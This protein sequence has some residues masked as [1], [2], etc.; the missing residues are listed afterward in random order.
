MTTGVCS[1]AGGVATGSGGG[2]AAAVANAS[3]EQTKSNPRKRGS[4]NLSTINGGVFAKGLGMSGRPRDTIFGAE[5]K[6]RSDPI[7]PEQQDE[8]GR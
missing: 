5:E 1:I 4:E 7:K 6:D 2:G 8:R 3:D